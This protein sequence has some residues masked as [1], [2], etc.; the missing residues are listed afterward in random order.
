MDIHNFKKV[1]IT[2]ITWRQHMR[3]SILWFSLS[4]AGGGRSP[5]RESAPGPGAQKESGR[6]CEP[7]IYTRQGSSYFIQR[8]AWIRALGTLPAAV[9]DAA[10]IETGGCRIP[11]LNVSQITLNATS[12]TAWTKPT[13]IAHRSGCLAYSAGVRQYGGDGAVER[14]SGPGDRSLSGDWSGCSPGTGP[15]GHAGCRLCQECRQNRGGQ[16]NLL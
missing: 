1:L 6:W 15:A 13:E 12:V 8:S 14:Q 3:T 5:N 10:Q 7:N 9:L 2:W 16:F 4:P 11:Q